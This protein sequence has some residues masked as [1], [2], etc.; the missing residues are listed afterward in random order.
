M[1]TRDSAGMTNEIDFKIK[2]LFLVYEDDIL[3][4]NTRV[5]S[6]MCAESFFAARACFAEESLN[7]NWK[8]NAYSDMPSP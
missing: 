7:L 6:V 1:C 2:L 3:H 5:L 4:L 8:D